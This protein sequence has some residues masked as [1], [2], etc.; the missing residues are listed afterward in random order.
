M[1]LKKILIVE[2][3]LQFNLC[4]SQ[5]NTH[6]LDDQFSVSE[7]RVFNLTPNLPILFKK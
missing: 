4:V 5:I 3:D 6:E 7:V 2:I 1:V